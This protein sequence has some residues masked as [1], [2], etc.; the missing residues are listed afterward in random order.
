MTTDTLRRC[1]FVGDRVITPEGLRP[2]AVTVEGEKIVAIGPPNQAS[3]ATRI[4][5]GD[6]V[7]APGVVDAHVHINE[8]GRTEWEG[9]RTATAAAAAGGVTTLIDMPLNS[10]PVT[11]DVEALEAKRAA[12]RGQSWVDLA[13]YGGLIAGGAARVA[14]LVRAGVAG[15]KAFLCDSGLDEFPPATE[16]DLREAA[17]QLAEPGTPLLIHAELPTRSAPTI[18]NSRRYSE[19]LATR[20]G[21]WETD[22]IEL[23]IRICRDTGCRVHVVHL[24]CADALPM[25]RSARAEGLPLTVET[26]P[27][28]LCFAAEEIA[29]G[30]TRFKCAPPIRQTTHREAL[31]NAL[32]EGDIDTIGSDHSPCPPEMKQQGTGDFLAAWG[33]VSGLQLTL[34]VVWTEARRRGV[35]LEQIFCWL[36]TRPADLFGL[37]RNK[38][39]ISVG[40]DAD[41]VVFDPDAL[42][43]VDSQQLLHRHKVT[44]YDGMLLQGRVERTFVRGRC[45]FAEKKFVNEP[46]GTVLAP[47]FTLRKAD[48]KHDVATVLNA[49][50]LAE[51]TAALQQCCGSQAWVAA[52]RATAPFDDP[53]TVRAR[54]ASVWDNLTREDWLEAFAAHPRI[55]DVESLREK[56]SA[57]KSWA[58][59]EQSGAATASDALL[60]KL[61]E[62]NAAYEARFGCLFIICATGKSAKEML[63]QLEQR[64]ANTPDEELRIAAAEQ[65]KITL[66]RL[67][68]LAP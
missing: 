51:L 57:T 5:L 68:K 40:C 19:Y 8:P 38:G 16:S 27:H 60:R 7:L 54:A 24:A 30:D 66:L 36:S 10:S 17:Q 23:L 11:V 28:Y 55:G 18:G 45:V 35:G 58:V 21:V 22:A 34:P 1:V 49:M 4:E 13:M 14:P 12:A 53:N 65:L 33:G 9:F 32:V 48:Q 29:A 62:R 46:R 63:D 43:R 42:W 50:S 39:K 47:L 20:P 37:G 59:D 41:L 15:I 61:A 6:R 26:C 56:Y 25:I 31:W 52:M 64:M 67:E 2:A 44:P 3:D